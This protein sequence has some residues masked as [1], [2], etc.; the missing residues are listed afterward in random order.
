MGVGTEIFLHKKYGK[1]LYDEGIF[2]PIQTDNNSRPDLRDLEDPGGKLALQFVVLFAFSCRPD[3]LPSRLSPRRWADLAKPEFRGHVALPS[4][5]LPIV[6]DLLGALHH[7]LGEEQ[8]SGLASNIRMSLHPAQA[9]PNRHQRCLAWH[10]S[11]FQT[12]YHTGAVQIIPEDGPVV[13]AY[14]AI[15]L[16]SKETI[17]IAEFLSKDFEPF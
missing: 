14:L 15:K 16:S 17:S 10:P 5:D 9:S 1:S 8:F 11:V 7:H 6:P 2:G 3:Q 12:S 4:L 13:P